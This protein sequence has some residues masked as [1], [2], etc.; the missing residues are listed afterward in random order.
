MLNKIFLNSASSSCKAL[1]SFV[2][3]CWI[4]MISS[5]NFD[6]EL[7]TELTSSSSL[8]CSALNSSNLGQFCPFYVLS[9]RGLKSRMLV[10]SLL[11]LI[12]SYFQMILR[13]SQ[14]L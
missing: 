12:P 8:A 14:L 7:V 11:G 10:A 4:A 1:L 2:M 13:Q 6:N 3:S 9:W 5:P